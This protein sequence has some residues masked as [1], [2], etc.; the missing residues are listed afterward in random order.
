MYHYFTV[1]RSPLQFFE[2][3]IYSVDRAARILERTPQTIRKLCKDGQI[4]ARRDKGGY[5]ISGW[6][7]RAFA[8]GRAVCSEPAFPKNK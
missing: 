1:R 4:T 8:E 5:F 2:N 6:A 7:I 3:E